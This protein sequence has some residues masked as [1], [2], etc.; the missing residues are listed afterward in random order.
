MLRD[1]EGV[2][3]YEQKIDYGEALRDIAEKV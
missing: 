2:E 1:M 3:N